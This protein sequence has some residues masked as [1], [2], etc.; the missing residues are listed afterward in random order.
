MSA[1]FFPANASTATDPP[2][3][4][5]RQTYASTSLEEAYFEKD[6]FAAIVPGSADDSEAWHRIMS[7]DP[8]EIMPS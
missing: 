1:P 4:S 6:G 2:K 7:D 3:S 5:A 8:D